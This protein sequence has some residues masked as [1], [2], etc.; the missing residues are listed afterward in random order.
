MKTIYSTMHV[1][2][3]GKEQTLSAL[4]QKG[5]DTQE[6]LTSIHQ[7]IAE[8]LHGHGVNPALLTAKGVRDTEREDGSKDDDFYKGISDES[9][10]R[11]AR[12]Y[13]ESNAHAIINMN[14]ANRNAEQAA[15]A[16]HIQDAASKMRNGVR[17]ALVALIEG[18]KKR[19]ART[20][21][22]EEH[23]IADAIQKLI[24]KIQ[25][26]QGKKR[27]VTCGHTAANKSL[28]DAYR[29]LSAAK[30]QK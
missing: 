24:T 8:G 12:K 18:K 19:K 20:A 28:T 3:D 22:L 23:V 13:P 2:V 25:D 1:K 4:M 7:S 16:K 27:R 9:L 6:S 21:R 5:F 17:E 15:T 10:S 14:P 11:Y 26:L 30:V 29:T